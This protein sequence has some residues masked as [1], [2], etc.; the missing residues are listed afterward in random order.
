MTD[1][2]CK[3]LA[4]SAP[5]SAVLGPGALQAKGEGPHQQLPETSAS[6]HPALGQPCPGHASRCC[7]PLQTRL[8]LWVTR[9]FPLR[10]K[11]QGLSSNPTLIPGQASCPPP[12]GKCQGSRGPTTTS[13][14]PGVR[15]SAS[16][17]YS[18]G[19]GQRPCCHGQGNEAQAPHEGGQASLAPR[20]LTPSPVTGWQDVGKHCTHFN[21][22]AASDGFRHAAAPRKDHGHPGPVTQPPQEGR[23]AGHSTPACPCHPDLGD[24]SRPQGRAET[25]KEDHPDTWLQ[26]RGPMPRC[27]DPSCQCSPRSG[28]RCP[29]HLPGARLRGDC[30][31][32]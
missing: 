32:G 7:T 21:I 18:A 24:S 22:T 27:P 26:P 5:H 11:S 23:R 29:A 20:R 12:K 9:F 16:A 14:C 8:H 17:L 15:T 31:P 2:P 3:H 13:P 10:A 6:H 19:S 25:R 28:G 30:A 4:T 1:A